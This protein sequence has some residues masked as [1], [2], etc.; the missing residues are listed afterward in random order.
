MAGL[1]IAS[2][3][4][5]VDASAATLLIRLVT[6]WFG[7]ALGWLVLASRPHVMGRLAGVGSDRLEAD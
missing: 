7:I 4:A 6:M 3:M 2:G 5:S 1:L